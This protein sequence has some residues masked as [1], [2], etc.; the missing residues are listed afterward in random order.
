MTLFWGFPARL[1]YLNYL[2]D[3]YGGFYWKGGSRIVTLVGFFGVAGEMFVKNRKWKWFHFF[4]AACN[5][6]IPNYLTA[7][8]LGIA[9][10]GIVA[11]RKKLY[12]IPLIVIMGLIVAPYAADR[13][14]QL[15]DEFELK[16]GYNPK[17][18][19]YLSV[20]EL[21]AKF[22]LTIF[23]G[24]GTGQFT[25]TPSL[26]SS[27]YLSSLST[28]EI[29]QLPGLF[30]TDYH[31]Q[32]L[33]PVFSKLSSDPSALMSSANKP[34]NSASTCLAEYGVPFSMVILYFYIM[35]FSNM[36]FK[37]KYTLALFCFTSFL[38]GC[39]LWHDNLWYGYLL[40]LGSQIS[41]EAT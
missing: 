27:I 16:I 5:F 38:F 13:F 35:A 39:D 41:F 34:Y 23:A 32:I 29:P 2:P 6:I 40:L 36:D 18:F 9:S 8:I 25:G 26:W 3:A 1:P 7:L 37:K 19:A 30:M 10:L 11:L 17:V 22:P 21:Y 12:L 15:N 14:T 28:H 4:I 33:G 31:R 24:T 20:V